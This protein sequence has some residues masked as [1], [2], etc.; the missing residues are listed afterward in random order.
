M[1]PGTSFLKL[2]RA[3]WLVAGGG[4][5][6]GTAALLCLRPTGPLMPTGAARP[7]GCIVEDKSCTNKMK[8]AREPSGSLSPVSWLS[9]RL[10]EGPGGRA[11]PRDGLHAAR[12]PVT[13]TQHG[14][15]SKDVP[16]DL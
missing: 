5:A 10:W 9:V 13:W 4:G 2:S 8:T 6:L 16:S 12:P 11:G 15:R 7:T 3:A 1:R 14:P